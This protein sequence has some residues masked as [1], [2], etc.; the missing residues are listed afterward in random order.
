MQVGIYVD[1]FNL[2]YG[3]R[4]HAGGSGVA[5]WR[6]L[7]IRALATAVLR[8]QPTLWPH[9]QISL[10]TY[11]T[12]R[13]SARDNA[14]GHQDQD[15]YLKALLATRSVNH[16][17]YGYYRSSIKIRP[18]A[19]PDKKKRPV[20]VN[21]GWPIKV[22]NGAQL[23]DPDATFMVSVADREEKGSDVNVATHLLI[24]IFEKKIDAAVVISNDSDLALPVTQARLRV[25]VGT[26][27]PGTNYVAGALSGRPSDGVGRHWWRQLTPADFTDHQL[28][29]PA[30]RYRMP[31]GW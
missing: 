4:A 16:I 31:D 29:D 14:S 5:G 3:G 26:V 20:L 27:H 1:G 19:V 9:A 24:D 18:M 25:P 28:P 21:P 11:C 12:A 17:E 23:D 8:E 2:Y 7:D 13:I 22:K 15:V 30:G 6:W 10:I